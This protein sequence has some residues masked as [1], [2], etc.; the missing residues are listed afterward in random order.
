VTVDVV[1]SVG[2][3]II[4]DGY[5]KDV[6]GL[7]TGGATVIFDSAST[8]EL[9]HNGGAASGIPT[10]TWKTG[11]TCLITGASGSI[12]ST[13]GYNANQDFYNL[14]INAAITS[15]KDLAMFGNTINGALTINNTGSARIYL[16]SPGAGTFNTITIKGNLL[17]TAGQF[18]TNGSSG[19]DTITINSYGNITATGGNFSLSRGS[20]PI[21]RWNS[22][23]DSLSLSN[24]TTEQSSN[25]TMFVFAKH[26]R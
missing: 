26:V 17:L 9:A 11:S 2:G 4:V 12:S 1:D 18:S 15:N 16:T 19:Q 7:K 10:A 13:T 25:K 6:A 23:G 22:Y 21:V 3:N 14:T 24:A 5:L 20:V 8:Y